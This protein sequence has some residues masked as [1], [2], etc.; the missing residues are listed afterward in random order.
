MNVE[1]VFTGLCSFLNVNGKNET[2]TEPSVILVRTDHHHDTRPSNPKGSNTSGFDV[3]AP[4][5]TTGKQKETA[6]DAKAA[7]E[8]MGEQHVAFIAFDSRTT[9]EIF[10]VR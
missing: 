7:M 8:P 9:K 2:M 4:K 10:G 1:I 6:A 3:R 5:S